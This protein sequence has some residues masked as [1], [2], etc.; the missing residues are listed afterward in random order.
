M[1]LGTPSAYQLKGVVGCCL[2]KPY[3]AET[4]RAYECM[5]CEEWDMIVPVRGW[6]LL[7]TREH[8]QWHMGEG[9]CGVGLWVWG[10]LF[11]MD[12]LLKPTGDCANRVCLCL[13]SVWVV[14]YAPAS[15]CPWILSPTPTIWWNCCFLTGLTCTAMDR[16][17]HVLPDAGLSALRK[18]STL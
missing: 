15:E 1:L 5:D 17:F 13:V 14:M 12:P 10:L 4:P 18:R 8:A 6:L 16:W 7:A 11:R 3:G 2:R 9:L